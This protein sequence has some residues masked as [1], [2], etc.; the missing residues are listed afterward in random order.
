MKKV[1]LLGANGQLGSDIV[2]VFKDSKIEL[3]ELTRK[4]FD[5]DI[6]DPFE[7]LDRYKN[8]QY[9]INCIAYHKT[10]QC[11]MNIDR[12]FRINSS[13]VLTLSKYCTQNKITFIHI[14]TDYVFDGSRRELYTEND[15]PSPLNVY[16]I[17]KFA[18]ESLVKVYADKYFILRVSSLFGAK[19]TNNPEINFVE[20]MIYNAN[21]GTALKVIDDQIMS[22]THTLEV[23]DAIFSLIEN[24]VTAYGVYHC[25][26]TGECSWFEFAQKIFELTGLKNDLSPVSYS[27]FHTQAKRPQFCSM[28]NSK[29]SKYYQMKPWAKALEDYLMIKGYLQT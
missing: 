13:L 22:P 6:D 26:N 29:M 28:D 9:L 25:C 8:C 5:A 20:K 18:G 15:S 21:Q 1:I 14:S 11:E 19:L 3:V 16:G 2:K 10:D 17:S 23:A 27:Q 24:N 12:S 7:K 4:E